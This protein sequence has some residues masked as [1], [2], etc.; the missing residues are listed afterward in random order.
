MGHWL[1]IL[2]SCNTKTI[3]P[4]LKFHFPPCYFVCNWRDWKYS[5]LQLDQNS[6]TICWAWCNL[7][8]QY[9]SG[10]L[11]SPGRGITNFNSIVSMFDKARGKS[12]V[13]SL[14]VSTVNGHE[15]RISSVSA[16]SISRDSSSRDF[17]CVERRDESIARA[18]LI[19][20]SQ[21]PPMW[22]AAGGFL[23]HLNKSPPRRCMKD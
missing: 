14:M 8:Q 10:L 12:L 19:C 7:F 15:L 20:L 5:F 23:I 17:P 11:K 4:T 2:L 6:L 13:G 21:M 22:L 3:L 16:T 18:D 1:Q 9:K